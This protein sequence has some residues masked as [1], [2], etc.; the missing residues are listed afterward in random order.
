MGSRS[1]ELGIRQKKRNLAKPYQ[2]NV[3]RIGK[4]LANPFRIWRTPIFWRIAIWRISRFQR[5]R[6]GR[7]RS[8]IFWRI[9]HLANYYVP[10][11]FDIILRKFEKNSESVLFRFIKFKNQQCGAFRSDLLNRG[12]KVIFYFFISVMSTFAAGGGAAEISRKFGAA[13]PATSPNATISKRKIM[14]SRPQI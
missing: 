4:K 3:I 5:L 13:P 14:K 12:M 1:P 9:H 8:P 10:H 11:L 2:F 7:W 6:I